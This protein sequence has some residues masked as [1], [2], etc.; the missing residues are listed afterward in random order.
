MFPSA[1]TLRPLTIEDQKY[2]L[3]A[4]KRN[5]THTLFLSLSTAASL[6]KSRTKGFF[7]TGSSELSSQRKT[8]SP[9]FFD[10]PADLCNIISNNACE[11]RVEWKAPCLGLFR[12]RLPKKFRR[13][14]SPSDRRRRMGEYL[15][16]LGD[17]GEKKRSLQQPIKFLAPYKMNYLYDFIQLE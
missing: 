8:R 10:A 11:Q 14:Y 2:F 1:I 4:P 16:W 6:I 3:L 9:P 7:G 12:K 5:D 13:N 17:D 15:Q